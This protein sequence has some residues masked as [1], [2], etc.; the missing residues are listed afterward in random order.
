MPPPGDSTTANLLAAF[1]LSLEARQEEIRLLGQ[2]L[3][4]LR[5]ANTRLKRIE[6]A[7]DGNNGLTIP[8]A[9]SSFWRRW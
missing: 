4:E 7:L 2:I 5:L 8:G 1:H 3:S 9:I 6:N